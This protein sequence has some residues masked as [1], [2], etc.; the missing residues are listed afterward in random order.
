V[1]AQK[2]NI[3]N[4]FLQSALGSSTESLTMRFADN[5][6]QYTLYYYD[7]GGNLVRTVPP[8]GVNVLSADLTTAAVNQVAG[9]APVDGKAVAEHAYT[10]TYAYN[11]LNQLIHQDIPDHQRI[12]LWQT[13]AASATLNGGTVAAVGYGDATHG[14]MLSNTSTKGQLL[15]TADAGKTWQASQS[16]GLGKITSISRVNNTV[17]F[18]GGDNGTFLASADAGHS[19]SLFPLPSSVAVKKVFFSDASN[20]WVITQDGMRYVTATGGQSWPSGS[21]SAS[22]QTIMGT[23]VPVL[24]VSVSGSTIWVIGSNNSIYQSTD[25]GISWS[26]KTIDSPTGS[27]VSALSSGYG[28]AG[29]QGT[30]FT[31]SGSS[32]QVQR[33]GLD[34][35]VQRIISGTT[36]GSY[37]ALTTAGEVYYGSDLQTWTNTGLS[38]ITS[39]T[40]EGALMLAYDG[41]G[42]YILS[43]SGH[44]AK[45]GFIRARSISGGYLALGGSSISVV[46]NSFTASLTYA[47]TGLPSGVT[48]SDIYPAGANV[49]GLGSD[50]NVYEGNFVAA[51]TTPTIVLA[52][53]N[54]V[55]KYSGVSS[56]IIQGTDL[57]LRTAAGNITNY[58]SGTQTVTLNG[59]TTDVLLTGSNSGYAVVSGKLTAISAGV[60]ATAPLSLSASGLKSVSGSGTKSYAAGSNGE[61]YVSAATS[62]NYTYVPVVSSTQSFIDAL[63]AG[64]TVQLLTAGNAYIYTE[65]TTTLTPGASYSNAQQLS[66]GPEGVQVASSTAATGNAYSVDASAYPFILGADLGKMWYKASGSTAYAAA[67]INVQPLSALVYVNSSTIL[68]VGKEGTVLRSTDAG[69]SWKMVYSTTTADLIGVSAAGN[70]AV[71]IAGSGTVIYSGDAGQS[72]SK[73]SSPPS[74][75]T[76]VKVSPS[77]VL[78]TSGNTLY[79]STNGGQN[80]TA[81]SFGTSNPTA[82]ATLRSVWLDADGYGFVVGDAGV[83]YRIKPATTTTTNS[84]IYTQVLTDANTTDD[85]GSGIPVQNLASVQF[86]DRL[87]GYITGVNGL[88]LKTVDGGYH[89]KNE[90][91][92]G[93]ATGTGTPII[94][95]SGDAQN[96]TLVAADG[97]VQSLNDQAEQFSD[98]FWY[99]ELGRLI[100]SQNSKQFTIANYESAANLAAG[101]TA[102][103]KVQA[104]SYTLYDVIGR[105]TEV[106]EILTD[107]TVSTYKNASQVQYTAHTAFVAAA[108][109]KHQVSQT[110]YDINANPP[111]GFT[112]TYLRNR[113]AYTTYQQE[114]TIAEVQQTHYSYD[115]HGNV[116][117]LLQVINKDGQQLAKQ[118]NY[119]YDLVSGKVNKVYYQKKQSDQLIHKY[120]YDGDNRITQVQTSTDGIIYTKEASYDYYA[121]GPLARTT[122]GELTVETQNFAYTIQG[123]IKQVQGQ[124]FSYALGYNNTDYTAIGSSATTLA[125]PIA[126]GRGLYNG[127]IASMTSNTPAMPTALFQ[128]QYS[129]DQLN[130]ITA[131]IT[132][133]TPA[134][135]AYSTS[136][137]YDANGNI[138]TLSRYDGSG[139]QFDQLSYNYETKANGYQHT[140]NKLRSVYDAIGTTTTTAD[141]ENQA[142]DNYSYDAIGNLL[143]DKQEEIDHIEWTVLGKVHKVIRK[144]GSTKPNLEFVYDAGGQ[145]AVKKVIKTDGTITSTYY[146]RDA[147]GNVMS[148]YTYNTVS[149]NSPVLAEQYLYGSSRIGVYNPVSG[150][151][152]NGVV[153]RSFGR[154]SY[155][156]TDHL[157]NVRATLSDYR[158]LASQATVNSATDYYP[159]GMV[160]RNYASAEQYRYGYGEQEKDIEI[161]EG[162]YTAEYWEYDARLGRRWNVDPMYSKYPWQ[163]PYACFNNN[164]MIF[165]DPSGLE[166]EKPEDQK[167]IKTPE[168]GHLNI[169]STATVESFAP[170]P[171]TEQQLYPSGLP[172]NP[173]AATP[174]IPFPNSTSAFTI[175]KVRFEAKYTD[176]KFVGYFNGDKQYQASPIIYENLVSADFKEKLL[177][178]SYNLGHDPNKLMAVMAQETGNKFTANV[179]NGLGAVGLIQFTDIAVTAINNAFGTSYTDATLIKMTAT[180][181]LSVVEQYFSIPLLKNK[182]FKTIEDY[183]LAN[184]WPA[185][186]GKSLDAVIWTT[187]STHYTNHKSMDKDNNG[188]ITVGEIGTVYSKKYVK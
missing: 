1:A 92:A 114:P 104:Y 130:R 85:K 76:S 96:G 44:S 174:N 30:L 4:A 159:F 162:I 94:A 25:A 23:N 28:F 135:S 108:G 3:R 110:V 31:V 61:L 47:L 89:W 101:A 60:L 139:V 120:S 29:P 6:Q 50:G 156:L 67:A 69:A 188:K 62:A 112:P 164:P 100:L 168:G 107:Q 125:T 158:R 166:G 10:T 88:L 13:A 81:E 91:A 43:G 151:L 102:G 185:A 12:D 150:V 41:S 93:T 148:V 98:R 2:F 86:N 35:N 80:Y 105:I 161:G 180:E 103:G 14:L 8:S 131:S 117:S 37:Y 124:A 116:N 11:S 127:N 46:D 141:I 113:V 58:T 9:I 72:W 121:H 18:A 178:I 57:Y 48:L 169:P 173:P 184:I 70:T 19:W 106:G 118:I 132:P 49:A 73:V 5:E 66:S 40:G 78:I 134:S 155:E 71:A 163:S 7:Q 172:F 27:G 63:Y 133:A 145:R 32:L 109:L 181:Q 170:I 20:G 65:G 55:Q 68:S 149:D 138:K 176:G 165:N 152:S 128:Q 126:S 154:K 82:A 83:A 97:S 171:Q 167:V 129:Y 187:G 21:A 77:A 74:A 33:T 15:T 17:F 52:H 39:I 34:Q 122:I 56:F 26:V 84:F 144:A 123:W 22:L 183:A 36:A 119:E 182:S 79:K 99:D 143:S 175:D 160:A 87:T 115:V 59:S 157:G 45:A 179:K 186:M 177:T 42:V 140:T 54:F 95:L 136:Y 147:T 142:A 64:T 24:D 38:G 153:T 75:P 53:I 51:V 137:S 111:A 146:L 16:L 90:S